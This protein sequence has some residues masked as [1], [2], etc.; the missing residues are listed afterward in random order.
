MI[1][2]GDQIL[3]NRTFTLQADIT[4]RIGKLSIPA[5]TKDEK[6]LPTKENDKWKISNVRIHIEMALGRLRKF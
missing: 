6:W 5:F 1:E 2:N 4:T 3:A